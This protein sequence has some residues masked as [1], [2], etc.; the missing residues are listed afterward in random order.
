M[1]IALYWCQAPQA[2]GFINTHSVLLNE[3]LPLSETSSSHLLMSDMISKVPACPDF[4]FLHPS[5]KSSFWVETN[6]QGALEGG[7]CRPGGE[8]LAARSQCIST[9]GWEALWTVCGPILEMWED[10]CISISP[11]GEQQG[12]AQGGTQG[13]YFNLQTG[14]SLICSGRAGFLQVH[15]HKP[16]QAPEQC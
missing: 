1:E 10:T 16:T 14:A 4:L 13:R 6:R 3:S 11:I 8:A 5:P 9:P 12:G 15:R 2:L 7:S